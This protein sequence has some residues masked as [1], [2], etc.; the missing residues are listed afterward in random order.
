M[1]E[2]LKYIS[3]GIFGLAMFINAI[4]FIP[5]WIRLYK[6]KNSADISLTMFI[7]FNFI[8]LI[9]ILHSYFYKDYILMYGNILSFLIASS[10]TFLILFYRKND[11]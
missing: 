2:Y 10:I 9:T 5:Q 1:Q 8:Q 11:S 4:L 3:D 7:G 6:T